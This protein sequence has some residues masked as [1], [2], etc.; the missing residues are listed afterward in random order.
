ML[1]L[2]GVMANIQ[3][4]MF[5][6]NL[7]DDYITPFLKSSQPDFTPLARAIAKVAVFYGIGVLSTY[8][9]NRI[10][11]NVTQ[12]VLRNLRNEL[13][14]HMEKLPIKYFDKSEKKTSNKILVSTHYKEIKEQLEVWSLKIL[15]F[16]SIYFLKLP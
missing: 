11:V 2:V 3:G 14:E 8:A 6:K 1:I 10:M 7:I 9:Y 4:T 5:T 16:A 13:F 15:P 12:G